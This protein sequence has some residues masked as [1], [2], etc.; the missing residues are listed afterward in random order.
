MKPL[1]PAGLQAIR[2]IE[3]AERRLGM[4][5]LSR[6]IGAPDT[7]IRAWRLG[8]STIPPHK[9]QKLIQ[10][11]SEIGVPLTRDPIR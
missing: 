5:E 7:T 1:F 2:S 4:D 9:V 8:H 6:R 10:V 3:I 11:L